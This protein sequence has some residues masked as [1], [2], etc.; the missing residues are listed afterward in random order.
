MR[1]YERLNTQQ[2]IQR[3]TKVHGD[4]YD[5]SAVNYI[6]TI[7][8]V[9]ITCKQCGHKMFVL[10]H[11]HLG[12]SNKPGT[13]CKKC[14]YKL[15]PQNKALSNE[16]FIKAAREIHGDKYEY[17]SPYINTKTKIHI[18]CSK[19][20]YCFWQRADS[21]LEGCGCKK[22]Q[23]KNLPQ[24]TARDVN[25]FENQCRKL[26]QERYE[27][28]GDYKGVKYKIKI[29]CKKHN[30]Y[31]LQSADA[32]LLKAQGCPKCRLSRGEIRVENYLKNKEI[33]YEYEKRFNECKDHFE[34]SF[35]FYLLEY[36]ACI[37][38]D[39]ELHYYP[40]RRFGGQKKLKMQRRH[41][42]IKTKFCKDNKINLLRIP[43][44]KIDNT[45][46]LI[47]EFLRNNSATIL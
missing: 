39:G 24:N 34:L 25:I 5:Y 10:P 45:E 35:D 8:K 9:C 19:C 37:E 43:F 31:F 16:D 38:F 15:L 36:N 41:D 27:Y 29:W 14:Q 22:C 12:Y 3:A 4:K 7:S 47:E 1:K 26:H 17:L 13:G 30:E 11:N 42:H 28:Y 6:N 21:H 2:F 32:H 46:K 44:F 23:Y 20:S 40:I 33:K 18:K